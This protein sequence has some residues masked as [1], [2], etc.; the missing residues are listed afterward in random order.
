MRQRLENDFFHLEF[1]R[2]K[3]ERAH[4]WI[5]YINSLLYQQDSV[6]KKYRHKKKEKNIDIDTLQMNTIGVN[7]FIIHL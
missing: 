5:C 6:E 1:K 3:I 7:S 2:F 4:T